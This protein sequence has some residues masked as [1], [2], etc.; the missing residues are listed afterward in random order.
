M[1]GQLFYI[2]I[3]LNKFLDF[4]SK[5]EP[6]SKHIFNALSKVDKSG[7]KPL[8]CI[9]IIDLLHLRKI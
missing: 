3:K 6:I 1:L 9:L 2:H 5:V 7:L 4:N 8:F